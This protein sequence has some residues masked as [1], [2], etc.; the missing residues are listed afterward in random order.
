MPHEQTESQPPHTED[1]PS[2]EVDSVL[3]KPEPEDPQAVP[4][5][6]TPQDFSAPMIGTAPNNFNDPGEIGTQGLYEGFAFTERSD[7]RLPGEA[8]LHG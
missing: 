3:P 1:R 5:E 7:V 6:H 4:E 8:G 2:H